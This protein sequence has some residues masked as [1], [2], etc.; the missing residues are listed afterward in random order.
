MS[1]YRGRDN[2]TLYVREP[3]SVGDED[4]SEGHG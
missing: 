3:F 4:T 1:G 2:E